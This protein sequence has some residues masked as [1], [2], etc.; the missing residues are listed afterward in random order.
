MDRP[1]RNCYNAAQSGEF[2]HAP[3]RAEGEMAR[4]SFTENIQRHVACPPCEA[5][6]NTVA[7]VLE[8]VFERNPRARGYILDDRGAVRRHMTVFVDGRVVRDR[9]RLSDEVNEQSDICIMQA[10]SGG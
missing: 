8:S 6:G 2:H 9:E 1:N 10:L 4:V 5:P 7:A 3:D